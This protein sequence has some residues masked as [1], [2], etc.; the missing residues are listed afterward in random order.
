MMQA[1]ES[2]HL[3]ITVGATLAWG[4]LVASGASNKAKTFKLTLASVAGVGLAIF[5]GFRCFRPIEGQDL[6]R[7]FK[8]M[9][10]LLTQT[11][12]FFA[13][14][15]CV[16][17]LDLNSSNCNPA[18][19]WTVSAVTIG[20][21][22]LPTLYSLGRNGLKSSISLHGHHFVNF[23]IAP[24]VGAIVVGAMGVALHVFVDS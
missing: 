23:G 4:G 10:T 20:A 13:P 5:V 9:S 11:S 6:A 1:V 16:S 22:G 7:T 2:K 21:I 14:L 19:P 8:V 12:L 15:L 3:A 17:V 18:L 24:L